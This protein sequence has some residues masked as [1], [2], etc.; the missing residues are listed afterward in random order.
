MALPRKSII[1]LSSTPYYHCVSRCV[2]RA[3]LC[4]VDHYSG[5]SYE[6][7]RAWLEEK[8]LDTSSIFAIK[9]CS[10]AVMSNHYHVVLHVRQDIAQSWSNKEVIKRWHQLFSGNQFSQRYMAGEVLLDVEQ[11]A[12]DKYV[13]VWRERL[14]SIS[15]FM[16]IV[17][18]TIARQ[19]NAEDQCTG[20]F[21]ESR[22]KSQALLDD[23]ALLSCMAYV[24]LNPIRAN[25][26][27]TPEAS[28]HTSVHK[29]IALL[30][31]N[32]ASPDCLEKFVGVKQDT[33][34]I[35][36]KLQEYL[37]L[38]DWTGRIIRPDK[39]GTISQS[40]PPILER[41]GLQNNAWKML[42]TKFEHQF[43]NWVGSEHIVRRACQAQ[44]YQRT[45][46]TQNLKSL[47]PT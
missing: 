40:T 25:M 2:R 46:K 43:Q 19:A 18:E 39:R 8:L 32:Q 30:N 35:P 5:K 42:T 26:A 34:G 3:F 27:K 36:F 1:S 29:R 20:S 24:D 9:L 15:W 7:R 16:R 44:G 45:P 41:L 12:L 6:H 22:F 33:I 47:F 28:K 11:E 10:Y 4:G 37:E 21:W 13:K 31:K 23:R 17:N 38:V 14:T